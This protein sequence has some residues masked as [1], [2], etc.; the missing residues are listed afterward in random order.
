MNRKHH[1]LRQQTNPQHH[2]ENMSWYPKLVCA[3]IEDA[4][5]HAHPHILIRVIDGHS[6]GSQ[7]SNISS[8]RKLRFCSDCADAQTNLNLRCTHMT[9][10]TL[11]W[12]PTK[13]LFL[14][15]LILYVPSTI[16]QLNRD[17]SSWVEPVLS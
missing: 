4:D 16:F 13:I 6:I 11:C 15:D 7:G 2:D 9:T 10:C 17:G 1:N 3:P 14:F 12:I 5:Q 8:G